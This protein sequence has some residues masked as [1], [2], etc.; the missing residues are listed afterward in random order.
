MPLTRD[1]SAQ[2][3]ASILKM[4]TFPECNVTV[5][6]VEQAYTCFA[7]NGITN[8]ALSLRHTLN[9][10]AVRE[11]RAGSSGTNDLDEASLR[12]VVRRAEE[13]AAIAPPNPERQ[14]ALGPQQYPAMPRFDER[15]AAAR[16]PEMIPHIK[17]VIDA[18][19][20]R[21][22]VAAGFVE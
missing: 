14:P 13:L 12:A 9:V 20:A 19:Q 7:N 17:T 8:A 4:S 16:S 18:A 10:T 1:Q 21:K 2:I 22:L 15:T 5:N 6:S 3:T 11:G